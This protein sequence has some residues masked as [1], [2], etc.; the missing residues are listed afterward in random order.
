M[1]MRNFLRS[2]MRMTSNILP[3]SVIVSI[4]KCLSL[5][6]MFPNVL[7]CENCIEKWGHT[8]FYDA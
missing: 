6:L 4:K 2:L 7:S 5:K 3:F 1:T 8:S